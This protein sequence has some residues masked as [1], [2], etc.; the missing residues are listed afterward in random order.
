[1][2]TLATST[3]H[4]RYLRS[5]NAFNSLWALS[6]ND[7][8]FLFYLFNRGG[9]ANL[10][11]FCL[12]TGKSITT[13]RKKI[14]VFHGLGLIDPLFN[15][16]VYRRKKGGSLPQVWGLTTKT[17]SA[18]GEEGSKLNR[19]RSL[20]Q[21]LVP[22]GITNFFLTRAH[23]LLPRLERVKGL[24]ECGVTE[25]D[26]PRFFRKVRSIPHEI[27]N[28]NGRPFLVFYPGHDPKRSFCE[29]TRHYQVLFATYGIGCWFISTC[30]DSLSL[31]ESLM[32]K[33][34]TF[35]IPNVIHNHFPDVHRVYR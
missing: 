18:F 9:V 21:T 13:A 23:N 5:P 22:L 34:L 33:K 17:V 29:F 14:R 32:G 35:K 11:T 15:P 1:M 20:K 2:K 19:Y 6:Q 16:A 7:R 30:D 12:F 3:L 26:I 25:K 10:V 27:A 24:M 8:D 28:L 4:K 31:A